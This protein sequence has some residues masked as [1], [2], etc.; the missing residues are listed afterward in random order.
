MNNNKIITLITGANRGMGFEIA[1]ELGEQGQHVL[2]GS[3]SLV[4]GQAAAEKLINIGV[5]A[6]AVQ[7][8]VTSHESVQKAF[9]I[10]NDKYGYLNILINN[11]GA[12]FD[13]H[14][15][16]SVLDIEV[17]HKDFDIN[18][19][20]L[21]DVTQQF[22]PLL[23]KGQPAKIINITSMMGSLSQ[24]L[25]PNSEVYRA[26]AVGYQSAKAAANMF[27]IQLAKEFTNN[28]V[29]ISVNS[30]D[31]GI[32]A[33][34]FGGGDPETAKARG[35]KSVNQGVART[36][37]LATNLDDGTTATFSNTSG[38]VPW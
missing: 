26:S 2:L 36:I 4:N 29:A 23:K 8:D 1:K 19:F 32:V 12:A 18:Y 22:I 21:V 35:A 14:R 11:A 31:P 13:Q 38:M 30:I 27:T 5:Q 25:N 6:E 7:L 37:E 28:E 24:A 10:I 15:S 33:T 3:R 16:P 20:G 34:S 9:N 17:I